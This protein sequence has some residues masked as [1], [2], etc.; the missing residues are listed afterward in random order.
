MPYE[1]DEAERTACGEDVQMTPAQSNEVIETKLE[2]LKPALEDV[3]CRMV[4]LKE[5][6]SN[7]QFDVR[8]LLRRAKD[9]LGLP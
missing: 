7:G 5:E 2:H 8:V 4:R 6:V 9:R 3:Y 1:K